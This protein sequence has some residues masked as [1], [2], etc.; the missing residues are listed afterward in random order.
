ML[1]VLRI[2]YACIYGISSGVD[3]METG[4]QLSL[5]DQGL[6]IQAFS[7]KNAKVYWFIVV[8]KVLHYRDRSY[9]NTSTARQIC[10]SSQSKKLSSALTF[11]EIW[12]R[13]GV[14][15]MTPLEE[16]L[17]EMRHFDRLVC[18]GDAAS[19]VG[20]ESTHHHHHK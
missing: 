1:L 6:A 20:F 2:E 5:W 9:C 19:K 18:I 16:G 7:G 10:E 3:K 4:A 11:G 15:A 13:C 17:F 8:K 14:F 12:S